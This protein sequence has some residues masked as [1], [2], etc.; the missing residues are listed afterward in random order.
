MSI[1]MLCWRHWFVCKNIWQHMQTALHLIWRHKQHITSYNTWQHITRC[2]VVSDHHPRCL[3]EP[4]E[5]RRVAFACEERRLV[6]TWGTCQGKRA[7]SDV[8]LIIRWSHKA[9]GRTSHQS[10]SEASSVHARACVWV[11]TSKPAVG[12]FRLMTAIY[13]TSVRSRAN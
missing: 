5:V 2:V 1:N 11:H 8:R 7:A 12:S 4:Q 6:R 10:A 9:A 3:K 13:A